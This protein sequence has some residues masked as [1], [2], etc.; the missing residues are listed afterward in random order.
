MHET[1]QFYSK[2]QLHC[3]HISTFNKADRNI[4]VIKVLSYSRTVARVFLY[5]HD[6]CKQ[7]NL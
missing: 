4:V 5:K 6:I 2:P 3:I 7:E 1:T